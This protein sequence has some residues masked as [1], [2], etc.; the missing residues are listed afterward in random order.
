MWVNLARRWAAEGV[1]SVRVDLS[2]LGDSDPADGGVSAVALPPEA[3]VGLTQIASGFSPANPS[4]LVW[5]GLC[6][7]GYHALEAAAAIGAAGV[8]AVNPALTIVAPEGRL[9]R[10][11]S[12]RRVCYSIPAWARDNSP[13]NGTNIKSRRHVT[14]FVF[15]YLRRFRLDA[16]PKRGV[17]MLTRNSRNTLVVSGP[18]EAEPLLW[19]RLVKIFGLYGAIRLRIVKDLQHGLQFPRRR[20]AVRAIWRHAG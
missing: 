16:C 13:G 17:L 19:L 11:K 8:F 7:G 4:D 14:G 1:R 6:A 9:A 2:G 3:M 15:F 12:W 10:V 18:Q 5:V 20:D